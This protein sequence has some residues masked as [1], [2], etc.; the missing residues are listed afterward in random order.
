MKIRVQ[1]CWGGNSRHYYR[2][3]VCGGLLVRVEEGESW[4][5]RVAS[6]LLDLLGVEIPAVSRSSIRFVHV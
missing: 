3:L 1:R 6:E 5:R 2:A 4:S